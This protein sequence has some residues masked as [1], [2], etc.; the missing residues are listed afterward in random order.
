MAPPHKIRAIGENTLGWA[1]VK[2]MAVCYAIIL[3]PEQLSGRYRDGIRF[4]KT[5]KG[6]AG[7]LRPDPAKSVPATAEARVLRYTPLTTR[8]EK[9]ESPMEWT[10]P[11][12][13]EQCNR[14]GWH[15]VFG[16]IP[17]SKTADWITCADS[18]KT[19]PDSVDR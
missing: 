13:F 1:K 11:V 3:G 9:P 14:V 4:L 7:S 17:E 5:A 16:K 19:A 2:A 12:A 15:G 6:F 8:F 10:P 18:P